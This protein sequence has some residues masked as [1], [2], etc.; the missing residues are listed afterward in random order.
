MVM[1]RNRCLDKRYGIRYGRIGARILA[2][3]RPPYGSYG[4][5]PVYSHGRI[6][7]LPLDLFDPG[8]V[9]QVTWESG[10]KGRFQQVFG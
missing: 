4:M 1:L 10:I 8:Q 2:K 5:H 7:F 6:M 9:L 3:Q